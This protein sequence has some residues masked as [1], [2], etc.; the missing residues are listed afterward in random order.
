M[1]KE[2]II[3]LILFFTA[4][5]IVPIGFYTGMYG[6]SAGSFFTLEFLLVPTGI[7]ILIFS[8]IF[9]VKGSRK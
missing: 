1:N 4:V 8:F 2:T 7:I 5:I 9:L 6:N 3:G